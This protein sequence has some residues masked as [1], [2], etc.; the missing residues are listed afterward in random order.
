MSGC[1]PA[2]AEAHRAQMT[3]RQAQKL[4]GAVGP[5]PSADGARM[6]EVHLSPP[7]P[8]CC[9]RVYQ[10]LVLFRRQRAAAVAGRG[11]ARVI[12]CAGATAR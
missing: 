1:P 12:F 3:Q 10:P 6:A 2:W 7:Q 8:L 11:L 9:A 5:P 4:S